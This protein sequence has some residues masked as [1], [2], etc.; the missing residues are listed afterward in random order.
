MA[1]VVGWIL[2]DQRAVFL[3]ALRI[4]SDERIVRTPRSKTFP[5]RHAVYVFEGLL[6]I[7]LGFFITT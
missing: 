4:I 7:V 3:D 1:N 5:L 2:R 6:K